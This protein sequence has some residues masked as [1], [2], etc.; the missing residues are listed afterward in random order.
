MYIPIDVNE[1]SSMHDG[2]NHVH[3][4]MH[5][6]G[7]PHDG[8]SLNHKNTFLNV[9]TGHIKLNLYCNTYTTSMTHK[10]L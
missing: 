10:D 9:Q 8:S 7:R 4:F 1:Y 6:G 3:A 2:R 5:V